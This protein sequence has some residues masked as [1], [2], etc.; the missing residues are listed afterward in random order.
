MRVAALLQAGT[1]QL[2]YARQLLESHG[3]LA[4]VINTIF[5]LPTIPLIVAANAL[6]VNVP[7]ILL[8]MAVGRLLRWSTMYAI[9][10]SG[11]SV[12]R[13]AAGAVEAKPKAKLK[14]R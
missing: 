7:G 10:L 3:M 6:E 4:G 11:R 9:I 1:Q 12:Y 5:P 2:V 14:A 8:S 13:R